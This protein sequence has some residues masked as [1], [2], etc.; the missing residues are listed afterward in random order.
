MRK[1]LAVA[2]VVGLIALSDTNVLAFTRESVPLGETPFHGFRAQE[3]LLQSYNNCAGWTWVFRDTEGA[4][5]GT[6]LDPDDC[7]GGCENGGQ[8]CG[9]W[10]WS[11]CDP[12]PADLNNVG[13]HTIDP[14]NCLT[15]TLWNSGPITVYSCVEGDR[16]TYVQ[17]PPEQAA[18]NGQPFAVTLE[19]GSE[20]QSQAK[21]V[22]DNG[23]CNL[24][25]SLGY[26]GTF[27]GCQESLATC[28]GWHVM[29]PPQL[30]YIY[31]TDWDGDTILDDICSIYG[32][33]YPLFFPYVLG[34][35]YLP[36]N[37]M[38]R[39][40]LYCGGETGVDSSPKVNSSSWGHVKALY[41]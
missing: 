18:V 32:V 41:R 39:A 12:S 10:F 37:L 3:C 36:N 22:T 15:G 29:I 2:A 1:I 24:F 16:W 6:V 13:I 28:S 11:D 21:L 40:A 31:I 33:P 9:I 5:W 27:P 7:I 23:I 26:M 38:L 25:C 17:V 4:V 14:V 8:V 19:W 34:Y 30:T 35:G 20:S